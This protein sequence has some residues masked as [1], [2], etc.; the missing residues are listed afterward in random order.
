MNVYLLLC[1]SACLFIALQTVC[2]QPPILR[3]R[4]ERRTVKCSAQTGGSLFGASRGEGQ[5]LESQT[6]I[7]MY[8][9]IYLYILLSMDLCIYA[10]SGTYIS[11]CI[12]MCIYIYTAYMALCELSLSCSLYLYVHMCR[13]IHIAYIHAYIHR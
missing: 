5:L 1:V 2:K 10:L 4:S 7:S 6:Y 11:A 3:K 8:P 9:C 13:H 12:C